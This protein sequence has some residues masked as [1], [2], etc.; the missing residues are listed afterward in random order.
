[1]RI[2]LLPAQM[3]ERYAI[4]PQLATV[5]GSSLSNA[6]AFTKQ[7]IV[8]ATWAYI[9]QRNLI[10]GD[11]CRMVVCD[12]ALGALFECEL[13]PFASVVMALKPHLTPVTSIDLEYTLS[14]DASAASADDAAMTDGN[15]T[16]SAANASGSAKLNETLVAVDVGAMDPLEKAHE[17]VLGEW[18][19]LVQEQQKDVA[20]LEQQERAIVERLHDLCR[21]REWMAQFALDPV[22]FMRDVAQS[23][24]ADQQ[25]RPS[26]SR[27]R[28]VCLGIEPDLCNFR[29]FCASSSWRKPRRTRSTCRIRSS[30]RSRGCAKSSRVCWHLPRSVANNKLSNSISCKKYL[31]HLANRHKYHTK[32]D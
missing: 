3:P 4:S 15:D 12:A 30:S 17:R 24:Q 6:T 31:T 1:M 27:W 25:V 19:E 11:D 20:L 18:E 23:Q 10:K 16:A 9:K 26:V 14:L 7:R 28:R 13:L 5:I 21:K 29:V 2:K 22:G 8:M 32:I